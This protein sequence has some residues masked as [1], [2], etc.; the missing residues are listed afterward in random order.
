M[1]PLHVLST[2]KT[3]TRGA[4]IILEKLW[5][6]IQWKLKSEFCIK[7]IHSALF[8]TLKSS[9]CGAQ[10]KAEAWRAPSPCATIDGGAEFT[11][12]AVASPSWDNIFPPWEKCL[13]CARDTNYKLSEQTFYRTDLAHMF[14]GA[15]WTASRRH[16]R[17]QARGVWQAAESRLSTKDLFQPTWEQLSH[18]ASLSLSVHASWTTL[19]V[20]F[21]PSSFYFSDQSVISPGW[22]SGSTFRTVNLT[23]TKVVLIKDDRSCERTC[24][25][26]FL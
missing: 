21:S 12:R 23:S 2:S 24:L 19:Y 6:F 16:A 4:F 17:H 26:A 11:A 20:F 5:D 25:C 7:S 13:C 9:V 1:W 3:S 14:F 15:I 10:I 18:C 8:Y 22:L